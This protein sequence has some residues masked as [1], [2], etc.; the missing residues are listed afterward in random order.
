M[1]RALTGHSLPIEDLITVYKG[2]LRPLLEYA[3]PVWNDAITKQQQN[4]RVLKLTLGA[5]YN[6]YATSALESVKL[7]TLTDR[8]RSLCSGFARNLLNNENMSH[9]IPQPQK[10]YASPN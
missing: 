3:V 6:D 2:Y 7:E 5:E 1:L 9:L 8:R 4:Q 10:C